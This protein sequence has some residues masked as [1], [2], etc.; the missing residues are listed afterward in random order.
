MIQKNIQT[1]DLGRTEI[2]VRINSMESGLAKDDLKVLFS[3][4]KVPKTLLLPKVDKKEHLD[5][6][7]GTEIKIVIN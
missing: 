7:N 2:A 3:G 5:Q 6:V 1:L 4:E